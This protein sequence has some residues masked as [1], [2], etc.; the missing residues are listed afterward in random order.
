MLK[1]VMVRAKWLKT[2]G[3]DLEAWKQ[4]VTLLETTTRIWGVKCCYFIVT[5]NWE[6]NN[7][8]GL[9]LTMMTTCIQMMKSL[10]IQIEN[11]K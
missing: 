7:L 9:K 5:K 4:N 11:T 3:G 6:S 1:V 2:G 8:C 10:P